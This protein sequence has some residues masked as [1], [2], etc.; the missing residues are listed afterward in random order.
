MPSIMTAIS[1]G[2]PPARQ[3]PGE[4][5][6]STDD[7]ALAYRALADA[8]NLSSLCSGVRAN[9][10]EV[11]DL[12]RLSTNLLSL[13]SHLEPAQSLPQGRA[14]VCSIWQGNYD[15]WVRIGKNQQKSANWPCKNIRV[16]GRKVRPGLTSAD[17]GTGR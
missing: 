2:P 10:S 14:G 6:S 7:E 17:T 5:A 15:E 3:Q 11:T 4:L 16:T 1:S 9:A 13:E 12:N 8:A